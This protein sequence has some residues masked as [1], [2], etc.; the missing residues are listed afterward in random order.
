MPAPPP[1]ASCCV[2]RSYGLCGRTRASIGTNGGTRLVHPPPLDLDEP[3][4]HRPPRLLPRLEQPP[5]PQSLIAPHAW[6][7]TAYQDVLVR[8]YDLAHI[9]PEVAALMGFAV[10][11][12]G[13]ALWRFKW[14]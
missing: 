12:F 7:L 1:A 5:L 10:V 11:F 13:V 3:R 8:G 4:H 6:A 9:L 14:D 2:R